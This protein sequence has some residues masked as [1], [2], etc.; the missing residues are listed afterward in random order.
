MGLHQTWRRRA[1]EEPLKAVPSPAE[2]RKELG[3]LWQHQT[4]KSGLKLGF[5][6]EQAQNSS[7]NQ[8]KSSRLHGNKPDTQG[9]LEMAT[10]ITDFTTKAKLKPCD[11][12]KPAE[13]EP[14]KNL[15][16]R[17]QPQQN[18]EKS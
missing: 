14:M 2:Q 18:R 4:A 13:G 16:K 8:T 1:N 9:K 15:S 5:L 6:P 17:S 7:K 11:C 10:E 12:V 3:F